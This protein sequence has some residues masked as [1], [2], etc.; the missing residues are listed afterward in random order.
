MRRTLTTGFA[1]LLLAGAATAQRAYVTGTSTNPIYIVD[2]ITCTTSSCAIGT[3]SSRGIAV[4]HDGAI[5]MSAWTTNGIFRVDPNT[6]AI[7]TICQDPTNSVIGAPYDPVMN[8]EAVGGPGLWVV[9]GNGAPAPAPAAQ[10]NTVLVDIVGTACTM[11]CWFSNTQVP[12]SWSGPDPFNCG[13]FIGVGFTTSDFNVTRYSLAGGVLGTCTTATVCSLTE[14]AQYDAFLG[15]D[16]H[17]WVWNSSATGNVGFTRVDTRTGT[18]VTCAVA[19]T[20]TGTGYAGVWADPPERPGHMGYIAYGDGMI[21]TVD[22]N[23]CTI[24]TMCQSGITTATNANS[25]EE[26][27]LTSWLNAPGGT[28]NFHVN[29]GTVPAGTQYVLVPS[30]IRNCQT[31]LIAGNLEIWFDPD[32]N[33]ILGLQGLLPYQPVGSLPTTGERDITWNLNHFGVCGVY[34]IAGALGPSGLIDVSNVIKVTV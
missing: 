18:C 1:V 21:Y 5:Y 29:F 24:T 8:N 14:P 4:G 26:N 10:R 2:P 28:R 19:I 11:D 33:T 16:C 32:L 12:L 23:T 17:V 34:W 13:Q 31:P 25:V 3:E 30:L 15:E 20:H 9:D 6:C 7:T 22:L 27:Q